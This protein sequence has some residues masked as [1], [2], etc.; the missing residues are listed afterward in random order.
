MSTVSIRFIV[1]DVDA[2][3]VL[4]TRRPGFTV[5]MHPA[6]RFAVVTRGY[7]RLLPSAPGGS[8]GGGRAMPDGR[9]PK[10]GGWN[11]IQLEAPHLSAEVER[12]R[13]AGAQSRSKIITGVGAR[14]II[15]DDP[16]GNP[17]QLFEALQP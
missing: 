16:S 9:T 7:L 14:Q 6:P 2:A 13:A 10:P 4:Y 15:V 12:L 11:R 1:H 8:G 5:V 3:M 17:V